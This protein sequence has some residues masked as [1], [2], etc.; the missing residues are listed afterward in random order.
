VVVVETFVDPE[1][2]RGTTYKVSG[3]SELGS[4]S[5]WGRCAQDFYQP[6]ERPKQLWVKELVKGAC[7]K[8]RAAHLPPAWA[9]VEAR[10]PVR[11]ATPVREIGSLLSQCQALPEF[12]RRQALAYP[13][14]GMRALI[15]LASLCGVVRGQ[16]DLAAFARSLSQRQLQ[17]LG[18]RRDR[19]T[20]RVRCPGETAF[21]RVLGGLGEDQ[22]EAVLLRWQD[23]RL[24]PVQDT[25]IAIDG[26][27]LRHARGLQLV[28]AFGG[29]T[30]RWLG[31]VR[32]SD[33][34]NEIP[35][36]QRLVDRLELDGKS[37]VLDALH[38]QDRTAQKLV[39]ERGAH[40]VMSVKA[41]PKTLCQTLEKKLQAQRF[42][43]S[44]DPGHARLPPGTQPE[45]AR[46]AGLDHGERHGRGSGLCGGGADWEAAHARAGLRAQGAGNPLPDQQRER[47]ADG[48]A[49]AAGRQARVLGD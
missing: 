15:V 10:A 4:T 46:S 1:Y 7:Q 40:Y 14:A 32:V 43:P 8:L 36:A 20:G 39:F 28:S 5:G 16:R 38:T 21:F 25:L 41:N 49:G 44:A 13:V 34:S 19:R 30:G 47:G 27:E 24:G 18:F 22:V 9:G 17:S 23:Q 26:K 3:W 6:H 45:P 29:Q 48:R 2:F 11:C 33:K 35:A 12:R 37:V 42:P 31:T